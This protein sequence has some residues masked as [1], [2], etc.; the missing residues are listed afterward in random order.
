MH[1]GQLPVVLYDNYEAPCGT[2]AG[3]PFLRSSTVSGRILQQLIYE[4]G[5]LGHFAP[6]VPHSSREKRSTRALM[7]CFLPLKTNGSLSPRKDQVTHKPPPFVPFILPRQG[8]V[9]AKLTH[10]ATSAAPS[11]SEADTGTMIGL[12]RYFG[13]E[14]G[15]QVD[16]FGGCETL[17]S[18]KLCKEAVRIENP[19]K[20]SWT[21]TTYVLTDV[22]APLCPVV[23]V[24][25]NLKI[26]KLVEEK[27]D[28]ADSR[29]HSWLFALHHG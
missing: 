26:S 10:R 15:G 4:P 11:D 25:K 27:T 7:G 9:R 12:E 1:T 23:W 29:L 20:S 24:L 8:R 14:L 19:I 17:W 21:Q 5:D 2:L 22:D 13:P 6:Q 28:Q 16:G 3:L 18:L